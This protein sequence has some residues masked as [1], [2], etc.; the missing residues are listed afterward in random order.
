MVSRIAANKESGAELLGKLPDTTKMWMSHGDKLTAVPEV[1]WGGGRE[2]VGRGRWGLLLVEA[3]PWGVSLTERLTDHMEKL[4][5][6]SGEWR[7]GGR[8][9]L[10][11]LVEAAP[12]SLEV[13]P[14]W[15]DL[16]FRLCVLRVCR[17]AC[18]FCFSCVFSSHVPAECKCPALVLCSVFRSHGNET[19]F[20]RRIAVGYST[21][22][23]ICTCLL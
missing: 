1:G 22:C 13:R 5:P 17:V 16:L 12:T 21:Y 2:S 15:S 4:V 8:V 14:A 20:R 23:S 19:T 7:T 11:T 6:P 3:F 10:P 18:C 9:L